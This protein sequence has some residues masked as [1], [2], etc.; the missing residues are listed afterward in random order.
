M[1]NEQRI[2]KTPKLRIHK[3]T[4]QAYVVLNGRAIYFGNPRTCD[5]QVQY[6]KVIAEWLANGRQPQAPPNEITI[7]E[8]VARFW[9]HAKGYYRDASGN[10]TKEPENIRFSLRLM[11]ELYGSTRAFEFG[12]R[13]SECV[14]RSAIAV[15]FNRWIR[16]TLS[17]SIR[18]YGRSHVEGRA[19]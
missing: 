13:A 1:K 15:S 16:R 9:V 6:H 5:P 8:L 10:P 18:T 2:A 4:G 14:L 3:A 17:P 11:C 19:G 7:N 12:P